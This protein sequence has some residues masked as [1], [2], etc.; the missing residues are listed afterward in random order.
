MKRIA[1]FAL[2]ASTLALA[3]CSGAPDAEPADVASEQELARASGIVLA[4]TN[5]AALK[6]GLEMK[7]D[8]EIA[9]S[10]EPY[11]KHAV[12][13]RRGAGSFDCYCGVGGKLDATT[14][15]VRVSCTK[16]NRDQR[17]QLDFDVVSRGGSFRL[18]NVRMEGGRQLQREL[19]VLTGGARQSYYPLTQTSASSD[20]LKNPFAG[21]KSIVA[22]LRPLVGANAYSEASSRDRAIVGFEYHMD[23]YYNVGG[24]VSFDRGARDV[25]SFSFSMVTTQYA[26]SSGFVSPGRLAFRAKSSMPKAPQCA[27]A[28]K[29]GS[30][31]NPV[32][33]ITN[34]FSPLGGASFGLAHEIKMGDAPAAVQAE[35]RR[36]TTE[37]Q[38]RGF[39]GSDYSADVAGYFAIHASCTDSTVVGYVVWGT[40]SGEPDYHDGVV[41]GIDVGG[42]RVHE[43]EED[44]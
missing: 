12:V 31:Q 20:P 23:E 32:P 14:D 30:A 6:I 9:D 1:L 34:A 15:E 10:W 26:A 13:A 41:I 4:G 8:R 18:E 5:D 38:R 22:S 3:A 25:G 27:M 43:E 21:P 33:S 42:K 37:I 40:G 19:D 44:G 36:A 28:G 35:M 16:Y 29:A 11:L 39:P 24:T 17:Q 7:L 2:S